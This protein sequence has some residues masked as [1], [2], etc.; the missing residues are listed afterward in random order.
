LPVS[1]TNATIQVPVQ[2][3]SQTAPMQ[4]YLSGNT[5]STQQVQVGTGA[6]QLLA[7]SFR[8]A[9]LLTNLGPGTLY[10]G[11]S[12]SVTSSTGYP[13]QPGASITM[14]YGGSLYAV[15]ASSSLV[16]LMTLAP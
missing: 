9:V 13:L 14:N 3:Q 7:T 12:S 6:T 4:V 1:I 16:A 2:F 10:I 11:P 15:S 5:L 8:F